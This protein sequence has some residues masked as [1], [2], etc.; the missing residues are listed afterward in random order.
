[1]GLLQEL[2]KIADGARVE[3][4][5]ENG[6]LRI[7]IRKDGKGI[8]R[9]LSWIELKSCTLETDKIVILTVRMMIGEIRKEV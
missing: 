5:D 2:H 1:M 3:L 7:E 8:V 4:S 9:N 6:F